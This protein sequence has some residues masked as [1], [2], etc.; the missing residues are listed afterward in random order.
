MIYRIF[1]IEVSVASLDIYLTLK[2]LNIIRLHTSNFFYT[3]QFPAV[4]LHDLDNI[5]LNLMLYT[6]LL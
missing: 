5:S 6:G 3:E 4:T 1:L 2:N